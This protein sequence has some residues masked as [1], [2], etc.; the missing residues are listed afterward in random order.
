MRRH[1]QKSCDGQN[2]TLALK[3]IDGFRVECLSK[4]S[5]YLNFVTD[6]LAVLW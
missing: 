2:L 6:T 3:A 1:H 5:L 4:L